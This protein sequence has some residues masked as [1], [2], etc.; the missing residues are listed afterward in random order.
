M[1]SP[2]GPDPTRRSERSRRAILT[3]AVEL[4]GETGYNE[5]TIEA[6]AA[7]AGVGKQTIYRWWSGKG[8]VILDALSDA[9]LAVDASM[10]DT[11]DIR[12]DL[13]AIIRPTV[14]ELADPRLSA[15]S[16]A[17]SIETL[18]DEAL[19]EQVRDRLLRPQLDAVKDRLRAAQ[20]ADQVRA[21]VD[22]DQAVELL[23]GPMYYRWMFRT[24]P[25][26]QEYADDV[27]D[28]ALA[29]FGIARA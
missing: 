5:L 12:T 27:V 26:S 20:L 28:L 7:R 14:A 6:I 9:A 22:L 1:P 18:S 4:L 3:A 10:P 2:S 11:G 17:L 8:A 25:L 29:A 23:F 16:R 15:T 19:A 13:Y 21:D 24:G